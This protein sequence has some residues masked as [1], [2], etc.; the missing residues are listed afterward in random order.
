VTERDKHSSL[1]RYRLDYAHKRFCSTTLSDK[2]Y[3][4]F[5][6]RNLRM[7]VLSKTVFPWQASPPFS[8]GAAY[9]SEAPSGPPFLGTL[10]GHTQTLY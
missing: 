6:I 5:N 4:T 10:P 2:C 9:P 3:K 7:F 8:N 1:L